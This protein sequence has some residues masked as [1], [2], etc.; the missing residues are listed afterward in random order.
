MA[1][2]EDIYSP[3]Y[4]K[5]L[6]D[7]CSGAYR[8]WS[9]IASFG[10]VMMWRRQCINNMPQILTRGSEGFDLMAGT[11]EAWPYLLRRNPDV[12]S[13][14][15]VDISTEM[16]RLAVERLHKPR[17]AKIK[18]LEADVLN[19]ELPADAADFVISTFGMKTLNQEQQARFASELARVLKPG[20]VFSIIEASDPKQWRFHGLY[21]FYLGKM[22]PMIEALFLRGA[23]DFSMISIYTKN[24]GDCRHLASEI[25]AIGLEVEYKSYFFGYATGVVGRKPV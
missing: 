19:A 2:S 7:R 3:V 10:F 17:K 12:L 23:K 16:N 21:R 11:G 20:G 1:D 5:D 14:T 13:I 4:V 8:I 25:A 24:F 15:A 6:F 18:L 22:L 9:Q